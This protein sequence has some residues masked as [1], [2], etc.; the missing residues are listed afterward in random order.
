M[1]DFW[2]SFHEFSVLIFLFLRY[3][4]GS[5][6][7]IL[8][9]VADVTFRTERYTSTNTDGGVYSPSIPPSLTKHRHQHLLKLVMLTNIFR[10]RHLWKILYF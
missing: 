3:V 10:K 4:M 6:A 8:S 2:F 9:G 5:T 7:Y 1:F